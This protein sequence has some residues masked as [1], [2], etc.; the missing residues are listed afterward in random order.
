MFVS[1]KKWEIQKMLIGEFTHKL[2]DKRRITLPSSFRDDLGD[3]VVL[4]RGL[5][6]CVFIYDQDNW[7]DITKQLSELP[8]G[9]SDSRGLSRFLLSGAKEVEIDSAGRILVPN[10]LCEFAGL[11]TEAVFAG[12]GTR[13]E[14][15]DKA[16]WM[17]QKADVEANADLLAQTLGDV[18][19]I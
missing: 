8:F 17:S 2:D 14:L 3:S 15:W 4:T 9:D 13:V 16:E 11:D 10:F 6:G 18:G 1:G 12:V 5:D 7:T 19:M